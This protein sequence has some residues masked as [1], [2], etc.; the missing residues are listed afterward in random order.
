MN[1][2]VTCLIS[3]SFSFFPLS[4]NFSNNPDTGKRDF[5]FASHPL[6][7]SHLL[8]GQ[9]SAAASTWETVASRIEFCASRVFGSLGDLQP[10]LV[11][12]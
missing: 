12:H 1:E 6:C 4:F 3:S 9:T 11:L 8:F 10:S 2:C 7:P 5:F